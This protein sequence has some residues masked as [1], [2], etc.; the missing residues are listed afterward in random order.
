MSRDPYRYFRVEARESLEALGAGM[1][2][3]ER[4]GAAQEEVG[5]LLRIAHTLKG[6]A[7]VV[8]QPE[9]AGRAHAIEDALAPLRESREALPRAVVDTVLGLVDDIGRR[10]AALDPPPAAAPGGEPGPPAEAPRTLRADLGEVDALLRGLTEG[11][12]AVATMLG[13]RG[14]L[15]RAR[16][17]AGLLAPAL[18]AAPRAGPGAAART[19]PDRRA[20]ALADEVRASLDTFSRRWDGAM[21]RLDRQMADA[22]DAARRLRLVPAS[23]LFPALERAAR[24]VARSQGKRVAFRGTGGGVRLDGHVLAAIQEALLH[25]VRNAV[26][27]GIEAPPA[28][29]SAGKAAEGSVAVE[30]VRRSR[31]VAFLCTDDGAGVDLEAVRRS[32]VRK[33]LPAEQALGLDGEGVLR[34]LLGAGVSTAGAVTEESGRGIGL[35]VVREV[36][37]RVG[38]EAT[39]RTEAG[40]GTVL[41]VEVPLALAALDAVLVEAGG[42][43]AALPL[44]AV[45]RVL[46]LRPGE[47][48]RTP[49]GAT[50]REGDASVPFVQ[51]ARILRPSAPASRA[52]AACSAVVVEVA[53]RRAVIGVGRLLGIASILVRPLPASLPAIPEVAGASVEPGSGPRLVLDPEGIV[54]AAH[55]A[56]GIADAPAPPRRTILVIDDSMTTRM[57]EK[58]ILESAGYDV[59]LAA[60]GEEGEAKVRARRHD[61]VLVDVEM[62]GMDGFTFVERIRAD[63]GLRDLPAILVTSR[64]AEEDRARGGRV[65]ANG[66]VVKGE[67]DQVELLDRIRRLVG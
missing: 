63:P 56:G 53:D 46:R 13:A 47:V 9:I 5:R 36:A 16:R 45:R 19:G 35:D 42:V 29:A 57:L 8:R 59:D 31:S 40:R 32:L 2:R 22:R 1:L 14:D 25:A 33:G 38:G 10:V 3:L 48:A 58:S 43:A 64:S 17:A 62:P 37:R 49:G 54:A 34:R 24:D 28:R 66:Y 26:A 18:E 12:A 21:E 65:G 6:A 44:D 50:V 55:R 30:V 52:D 15:D 61:L 20:A 7:G 27:H 11:H 60:S 51:L 41:T 4:G 23:S 67:F 39:L